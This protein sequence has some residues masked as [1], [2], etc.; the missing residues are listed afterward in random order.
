MQPTSAQHGKSV[1]NVRNGAAVCLNSQCFLPAPLCPGKGYSSR[2]SGLNQSDLLLSGG[3]VGQLA[4]GGGGAGL[5]LPDYS[6][7]QLTDLQVLKVTK[8]TPRTTEECVTSPICLSFM[9]STS[10]I[11]GFSCKKKLNLSE[12]SAFNLGIPEKADS[13]CAA[14]FAFDMS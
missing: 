3:S 1:I 13:S 7:R 9:Y 2:A 11:R 10:L 14:V 4:I 5:Y 8:L 12:V 6:V